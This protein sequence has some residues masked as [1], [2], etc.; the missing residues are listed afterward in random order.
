VSDR[1]PIDLV[2]VLKSPMRVRILELF[3]QDTGRQM[4]AGPVAEALAISFPN[5]RRNQVAYHLT[6]LREARLIPAAD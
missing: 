3:T 1:P 5:A 2:Q 4:E 6:V